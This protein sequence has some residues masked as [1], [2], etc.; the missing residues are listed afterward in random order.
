MIISGRVCCFTYPSPL[1]K[2]RWFRRSTGSF[3]KN[4]FPVRFRIIEKAAEVHIIHERNSDHC[5]QTGET[6][7]SGQPFLHDHQQEVGYQCHPYLYLD[8]I[9]TLS[10]KIFLGK[11]LLHLLEQQFNLPSLTVDGDDF[12]RI[13][14][15][16]IGQQ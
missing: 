14:F 7:F 13:I 11:V 10:V 9:C 3:G 1:V 12:C 4:I 5:R 15:Q 16:V 6:P 8:G 2:K